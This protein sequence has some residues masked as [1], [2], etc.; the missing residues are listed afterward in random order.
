M[1]RE[2]SVRVITNVATPVPQTV[3]SCQEYQRVSR[4]PEAGTSTYLYTTEY[5]RRVEMTPITGR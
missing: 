1:S 4:P 2:N 3:G 5:V